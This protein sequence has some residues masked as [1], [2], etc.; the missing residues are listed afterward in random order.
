MIT[1]YKVSDKVIGYTDGDYSD[2][3]NRWNLKRV[4]KK[5][6]KPANMRKIQISFIDSERVCGNRFNYYK[7]EADG[8]VRYIQMDYNEYEGAYYY[9]C[10]KIN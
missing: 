6:M 9:E 10:F 1:G 7:A 5:L 8:E 2:C 3:I 4:A